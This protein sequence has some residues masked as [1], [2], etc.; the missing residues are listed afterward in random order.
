MYDCYEAGEDYN[1]VDSRKSTGE[2]LLLLPPEASDPQEPWC[3]A[4]VAHAY[5]LVNIRNIRF[6]R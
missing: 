6:I 5:R 4:S 3:V 2:K 1:S